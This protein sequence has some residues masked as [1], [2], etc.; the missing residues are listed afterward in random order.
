MTGQIDVRWNWNWNGIIQGC[1]IQ[2][3]TDDWV[4]DVVHLYD[5]TARIGMN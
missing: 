2:Y 3:S 5:L 1:Y 4:S